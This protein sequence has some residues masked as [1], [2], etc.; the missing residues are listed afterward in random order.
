[1]RPL[2]RALF[3]AMMGLYLV[4][5]ARSASAFCRSRTCGKDCTY[6]RNQCPIE[7][8][9]LIWPGSCLSYTVQRDGSTSISH[10]E[11]SAAADAAFRTWQN[12]RCFSI[13][14]PPSIAV[15]NLFGITSCD[16]VEFNS[17]Q[18]NANIIVIR[19]DWEDRPGNALGLTT[20]SMNSQT[21]AIYD[22]D[23]EINGTQPLSVGA[24]SVNRYDLE[25]IITHEAGH[26][27]GI[28]HSDVECPHGATMCPSAIPGV[29]D[30]RTLHD[31]DIA[32]I[33]TIYPPERDRP[34]CD[35]TPH[36]GF[37]PE[38]GMDPMTGGACS[39]AISSGRS[40]AGWMTALVLGFSFGVR[41]R[42]R[43]RPRIKS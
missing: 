22:A 9:P 23:M 37:S 31:D 1:M 39:V 32:A 14:A 24:L 30:F 11:L 36:R 25:S 4:S 5:S 33:C 8:E 41:R 17:R 26:F 16:R 3:S 7:G 21:G 28:A 38:C 10:A 18:A 43:A 6:D 42:C 19:D 13:A 2:A 35:P 27:L 40:S 34:P 12:A 15:Q 20:V 29:D